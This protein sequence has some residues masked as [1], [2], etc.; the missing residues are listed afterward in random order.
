MTKAEV[1]R[2]TVTELVRR[3]PFHPFFLALEDGNRL[4]VNHPE[5]IAFGAGEGDEPATLSFYV[6]AGGNFMRSTFDAV[7]A[8]V[9]ADVGQTS[10]A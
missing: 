1:H 4:S 3:N 10:T 9:E 7:T 8:I 5:N 6:V 2:R